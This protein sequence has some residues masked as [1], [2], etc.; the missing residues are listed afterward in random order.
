MSCTIIRLEEF[1]E[2]LTGIGMNEGQAEYADEVLGKTIKDFDQILAALVAGERVL[3]GYEGMF[4]TTL[5]KFRR[6]ISTAF[7]VIIP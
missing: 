6:A 4:P 5:M 1:R 2:W 7:R 3:R